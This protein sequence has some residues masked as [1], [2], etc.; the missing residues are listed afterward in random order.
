MV[1]FDYVH[2]TLNLLS[3]ISCVL[4]IK[5]GSQTMGSLN[6]PKSLVILL[7]MSRF[8]VSF[9]ELFL[10]LVDSQN[11]CAVMGPAKDFANWTA[12]S[13]SCLMSLWTILA[14]KNYSSLQLMERFKGYCASAFLVSLLLTLV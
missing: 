8:I 6:N 5:H 9:I 2:I 3:L 7:G 11:I 4:L 1:P 13:W 14:Y 12:I 10:T